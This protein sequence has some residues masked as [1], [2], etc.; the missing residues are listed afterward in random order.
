MPQR[1]QSPYPPEFREEAVRLVR[2]SGRPVAEIAA[3]GVVSQVLMRC[4]S[5]V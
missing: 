5:H 1:H 3:C 4:G 2:T